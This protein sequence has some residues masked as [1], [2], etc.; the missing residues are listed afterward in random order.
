MHIH[1]DFKNDKNEMVGII[2]SKDKNKKNILTYKY[3][4][5]TYVIIL[6]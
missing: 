6:K 3:Y 4:L 1:L 2:L 5:L